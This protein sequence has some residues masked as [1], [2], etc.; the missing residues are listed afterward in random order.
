M[1]RAL[2]ICILALAGSWLSYQQIA[3]A[4]GPPKNFAGYNFRHIDPALKPPAQSFNQ[5]L[6]LWADR[7]FP[8]F[9]YLT[10]EGKL[11]GIAVDIALAACAEL[12]L[13]C[14]LQSAPADTL[15]RALEDGRA[16][17]IISPVRL[18]AAILAKADATRAIYRTSGHF[19]IRPQTRLKAATVQALSGRL[20]GL[21]EG[22]AHAAWIEHYYQSASLVRFTSEADAFEALRTGKIEV[23][24]GDTLRLGFWIDGEVSRGCCV[25]VPGAYYDSA[26]FSHDYVFLVSRTQPQLRLILDGGLDR[27]QQ[28]GAIAAAFRRYAPSSPW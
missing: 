10:P 14:S 15:L 4:A 6:D 28:S 26:Y 21:V 16:A 7:D 3:H 9:S 19:A 2:T 5:P 22:T 12:G 24:F 25:L 13:Q 8:P 27:A 23:Y 17:V 18:N 1:L 11:A 20:L